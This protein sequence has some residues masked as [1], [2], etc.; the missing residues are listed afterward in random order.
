MDLRVRGAC[1]AHLGHKF[2]V[3]ERIEAPYRPNISVE[4]M[5]DIV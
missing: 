1:G 5:P 2:Y 3:F 4:S